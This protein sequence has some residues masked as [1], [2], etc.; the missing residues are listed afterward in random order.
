MSFIEGLDD[1][2]EALR[3]L[4]SDLAAEASAIV[5]AAA[6]GAK[7]DMHYPG[8]LGNHVSVSTVNEG[9]YGAGA[10]VRNASKLAYIF[11]NGTQARHTSIGANRGAMPPG[12]VFIPA[13]IRRRARMWGALKALL[14]RHGLT[15][16]GE[17]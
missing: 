16:T 10:V 1:L 8:E 17:P 9:A 6:E 7:S 11:E 4:P 12:H 15:V 3:N 13:V 14:E 2:R 5:V